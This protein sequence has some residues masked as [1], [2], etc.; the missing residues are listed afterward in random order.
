MK[1]IIFYRW[2]LLDP[3]LDK[4]DSIMEP[5]RREMCSMTR[6]SPG[7]CLRE[8]LSHATCRVSIIVRTS[9]NDTL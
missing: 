4:E 3:A 7:T 2:A 6:V 1:K 5:L 9:V 8:S